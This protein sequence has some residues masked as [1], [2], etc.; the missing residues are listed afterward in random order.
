MCYSISWAVR[1]VKRFFCN[2]YRKEVV[3]ARTLEFDYTDVIDR[4]TRVFWKKGY[5][6]TSLRDLLK[7]MG[8]GEGSFYNTLGSKKNAYLECLRHYNATVSKLRQEALLSGNSAKWGVRALFRV[9]LECLDDPNTPSPVCLMA[10]SICEEVLSDPDL[11]AYVQGE[12]SNLA[13][14]LRTRMIFDKKA[15]VLPDAFDP[16]LTVPVIFTYLQGI[17]STVLVSYDRLK[18]EGQIDVFLTGLGL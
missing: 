14:R 13:E 7:A 16:D 9:V 10:G 4:A 17:W 5:A 6:G 8:L 18:L 12:M 15:G 11:R 3:L 2:R 1:L